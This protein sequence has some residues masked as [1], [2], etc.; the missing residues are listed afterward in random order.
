MRK[1]KW[2]GSELYFRLKTL[3]IKDESSVVEFPRSE[4]RQFPTCTARICFYK[5]NGMATFLVPQSIFLEDRV[6]S[7]SEK[8][9]T[10]FWEDW[11]A[12]LSTILGYKC[13]KGGY[14]GGIK[15]SEDNKRRLSS[16]GN[17]EKWGNS[18][19]VCSQAQVDHIKIKKS[20]FFPS[21]ILSSIS[22]SSLFFFFFKWSKAFS[23][24]GVVKSKCIWLTWREDWIGFHNPVIHINRNFIQK[25]SSGE[26]FL[27]E[28]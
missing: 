7:Q 11:I 9:W 17:Q 12:W 6:L 25:L 13:S 8:D 4:K 5:A 14:Q 21:T 24:L 3:T 28:S 19:H 27:G 16:G 26:N 20:V 2:M 22:C 15:G 1:T 18:F 23:S 10:A